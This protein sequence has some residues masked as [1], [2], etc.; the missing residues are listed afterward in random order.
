MTKSLFFGCTRRPPISVIQSLT[1]FCSLAGSGRLSHG[2]ADDDVAAVVCAMAIGW[3]E[4][5]GR[6]SINVQMS[7]HSKHVMAI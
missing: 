1:L 4:V 6:L 5:E 2:F 7:R 3:V